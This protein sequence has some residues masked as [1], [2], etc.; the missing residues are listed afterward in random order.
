MYTRIQEIRKSLKLSQKDFALRIGLQPSSYCD[1][2][3]GKA[4]ISE[5][6]INGICYRFNVNE[7]YL[8]TGEGEMFVD[9]NK[10]NEFIKFFNSL[11]PPLQ[12]FLIRTAKD[13]LETQEKL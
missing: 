2:E 13:L 4:P 1:I 7:E 10:F 6:T 9:N 5:R 8:R 12:D 3:H 11:N